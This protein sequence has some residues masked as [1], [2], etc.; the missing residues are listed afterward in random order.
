[1]GKVNRHYHWAVCLGLLLNLAACE[2]ENPLPGVIPKISLESTAPL[3]VKALE[4]SIL[5][6]I[7]YEDGDG[8]IGDNSI[9]QS[10]LFIFDPRLQATEE[11]Q[12]HQLVPNGSKVPI[13]GQFSFSLPFLIK[14]EPNP[15]EAVSFE[16]YLRDR[17]GNES[18]H[19]STPLINIKS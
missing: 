13:R 19:V 15:I 10:N 14:T 11:R 1:M 16:I 18:N 3:E 9:G 7:R 5:F 4:D 8:D 2:Q 17:A 12:I 6:T